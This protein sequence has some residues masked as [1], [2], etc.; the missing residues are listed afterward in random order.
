[1]HKSDC[2]ERVLTAEYYVWLGQ[3]PFLWTL[4]TVLTT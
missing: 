1:M 2:D 4:I 3:K